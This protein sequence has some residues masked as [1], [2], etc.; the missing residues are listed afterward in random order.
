M[1]QDWLVLRS[2]ESF[3]PAPSIGLSAFVADLRSPPPAAAIRCLRTV[4]GRE[5]RLTGALTTRLGAAPRPQPSDAKQSGARGGLCIRTPL[6]RRHCAVKS[7]PQGDRAAADRSRNFTFM[8]SDYPL[9]HS[10]ITNIGSSHVQTG[11]V[12]VEEEEQLG[13]V[14]AL[15]D[16]SISTWWRDT[17]ALAQPMASHYESQAAGT[18]NRG[19]RPLCEPAG[20]VW[21]WWWRLW[22]R[23]S[24]HDNY[25]RHNYN[26]YDRHDKY[27]NVGR[28]AR[29]VKHPAQ[30]NR[31][32]C[33]GLDRGGEL[34]DACSHSVLVDRSDA[35]STN[36]DLVRQV[37]PWLPA[38]TLTLNPS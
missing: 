24:H 20:G 6:G 35:R 22:R 13:K 14:S 17:V 18:R 37:L 23:R 10:S 29:A 27:D 34:A 38:L 30:G 21:Q 11:V 7:N 31:S 15:S 4:L 19:F 8:G 26:K 28:S 1:N 12:R 2:E 33:P 16:R 36:S 25:N 5:C 3:G 9:T 32:A